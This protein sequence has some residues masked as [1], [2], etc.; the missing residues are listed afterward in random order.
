[1]RN[2]KM[3]LRQ[4]EMPEEFEALTANEQERIDG[5]ARKREDG[6]SLFKTLY[7]WIWGGVVGGAAGVAVEAVID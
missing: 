4:S 7:S 2:E 6:G 5:G 3:D 1:M